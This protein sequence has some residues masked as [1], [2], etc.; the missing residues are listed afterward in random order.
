MPLSTIDLSMIFG[1]TVH[2]Q[3]ETLSFEVVDFQGPYSTIFGRPC[4]AKFMV[5]PNCT[6]L[7]L[8][9]LGP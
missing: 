1:D 3:R 9:M 4:C 5:V 6:Y 7:K 8:K 2:Y